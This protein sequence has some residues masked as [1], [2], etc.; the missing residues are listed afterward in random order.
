MN[1]KGGSRAANKC[2]RHFIRCDIRPQRI[3]TAR[4]MAPGEMYLCGN[5]SLTTYYYYDAKGGA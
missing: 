4:I 5:E 3:H 1:S 2:G